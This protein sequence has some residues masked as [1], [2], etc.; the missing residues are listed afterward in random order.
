[1][2]SEENKREKEMNKDTEAKGKGFFKII[3]YP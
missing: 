2:M 3:G 1:M